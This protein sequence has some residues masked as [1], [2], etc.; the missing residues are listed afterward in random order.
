MPGSSTDTAIT[1]PGT[2]APGAELLARAFNAAPN[3]F[4]IVDARGMIVAVNTELENMFGMAASQLIGQPVEVLLPESLRLTHVPLRQGFFEK[5]DS[6]PM[7]AGRV[8]MPGGQMGSNSR[9]KSD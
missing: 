2:A 6:R 4:L 7:G 5:P 1:T 9:S 8:Y 3:G